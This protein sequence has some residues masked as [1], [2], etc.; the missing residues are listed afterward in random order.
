MK[1]TKHIK[2]FEEFVN[3]YHQNQ[4]FIH[5]MLGGYTPVDQASFNNPAFQVK[6]HSVDKT[7]RNVEPKRNGVYLEDPLKKGD[8]IEVKSQKNGINFL[9]R[10]VSGQKNSK[11][12]WVEIT[13][14]DCENDLRTM[15]PVHIAISKMPRDKECHVDESITP[16]KS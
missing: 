2:L 3:E 14:I 13:M 4:T 7:R 12:E 5:P 10:F 6:L 15:K 8:W 1:K 16:I 11:G 9:G